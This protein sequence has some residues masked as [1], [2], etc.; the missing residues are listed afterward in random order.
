MP[1]FFEDD[2]DHLFQS[3]FA[4]VNRLADRSYDQ[5]RLVY[6]L[7][8]SAGCDPFNEGCAFDEIEKDLE[9]GWLNV[10]VGGG[11]W[12]SVREFAL[13][14]F[15]RA[16]QGRIPNAPSADSTTRRAPYA[17]PLPPNNLR[18]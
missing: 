6:R 15:H 1:A 4:H 16:R 12:A 2:D 9:N 17:D 5:V 7:G 3:H 10:R 11:E 18:G 14:G 13:A 8:R